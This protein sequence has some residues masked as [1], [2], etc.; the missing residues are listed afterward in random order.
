MDLTHTLSLLSLCLQIFPICPRESATNLLSHHDKLQWTCRQVGSI[1]KTFSPAMFTINEVKNLGA[2]KAIVFTIISQHWPQL[3]KHKTYKLQWFLF[4]FYHYFSIN[5]IFNLCTSDC[6]SP[7]QEDPTRSAVVFP[8]TGSLCWCIILNTT[9]SSRPWQSTVTLVWKFLLAMND[10]HKKPT[11]I[12]RNNGSLLPSL[13]GNYKSYFH[14]I[15]HI[16]GYR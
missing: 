13:S 9:I 11:S 2:S 5:C 7:P 10:S 4:V 15:S 16:R 8:C 6:H 1:L 12:F 3:T 14:L